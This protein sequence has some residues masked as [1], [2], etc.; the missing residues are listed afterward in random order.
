MARR[1]TKR[2]K[3]NKANKNKTMTKTRRPRAQQQRASATKCSLSPIA[4]AY[5]EALTHPDTAPLV[6]IPDGKSI[7]SRKVRVWKRGTVTTGATVPN[8]G[9]IC[10]P[11][12]AL[13]NDCNVVNSTNGAVALPANLNG[14]D[15]SNAPYNAAAFNATTGVQ[16]RLVSAV[17]KVKFVGTNLNAGGVEYGLQEPTHGSIAGLTEV[18]MMDKTSCTYRSVQHGEDWFEVHFRPV[19]NNDFS[20][21]DTI[22]RT[23]AFTYTLKSDGAECAWS[24]Y[25]FM[26]I[27]TKGAAT[28]QTLLYEFWAELEY[29][30]SN[31][32]GKTLTPPDAQ[33]VLSVI[34]AHSVYEETHASTPTSRS[35]EEASFLSKTIKSYADAMLN[36]AAPYVSHA[37]GAVG[38]ALLDRYVTRPA[39]AAPRRLQHLLQ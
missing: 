36:A 14:G 16:G 28:S 19:D 26:G 12:A 30:G 17:L 4:C 7:Y 6:G 31:V 13:A 29:A 8:V 15:A 33:G 2:S 20:W 39:L 10:Q 34:A 5:A 22:T 25:P 35:T 24:S 27:F 37:A 11:F 18:Q 1:R 32:Q 21:I 38:T 9:I 23:D 3:A